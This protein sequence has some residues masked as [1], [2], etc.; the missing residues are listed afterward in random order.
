[1]ESEIP[2]ADLEIQEPKGSKVY[3]ID[4]RKVTVSWQEFS[5]S[6]E[7]SPKDEAVVFIPGWAAGL[8]PTLEELNK[9]FA[10]NSGR[11]TFFINTRAEKTGDGSQN[12]E[13]QA[14]KKFLEEKGLKKI[15]LVGHSKGGAQ[16]ASLAG[17]ISAEGL[18]LLDSTGLYEQDKL[19]LAGKFV[20]D[21]MFKTPPSLIKEALQKRSFLPLIKGIQASS[22]IIFNI[23][24]EVVA[25]KVVGY[26][27]RLWAEL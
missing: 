9:Q 2:A 27:Q 1:M 12:S 19:E 16:V 26:P 5:P 3:E 17:E 7:N 10:K 11:N 22:D 23:A 20:F 18:I 4:G 13:T 15:I 6:A 14:I 24:K 25:S 21:S 8:P